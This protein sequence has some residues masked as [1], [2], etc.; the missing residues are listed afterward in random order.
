MVIQKVDKEV[1]KYEVSVGCRRR[2]RLLK[3]WIKAVR[4]D[5]LDLEITDSLHEDRVAWRGKF[6]VADPDN[7]ENKI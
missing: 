3:T 4:K 1:F 5:L 6:H 7:V 2:R